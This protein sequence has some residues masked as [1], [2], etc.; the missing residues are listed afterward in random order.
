M[1]IFAFAFYILYAVF[2]TTTTKQK[3]ISKICNKLSE[4]C[5]NDIC[6]SVSSRGI[7][8]VSFSIHF[9]SF[10]SFSRVHC[11]CNSNCKLLDM[12]VVHATGLGVKGNYIIA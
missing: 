12:R 5:G 4:I 11:P 8:V 1:R 2:E 10:Y 3:I 6:I 7:G 9:I